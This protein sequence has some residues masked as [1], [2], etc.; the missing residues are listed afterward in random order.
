MLLFLK[1]LGCWYCWYFGCLTSITE[2]Y[3]KS[4]GDFKRFNSQ[5][6]AQDMHRLSLST[7]ADASEVD[8]ESKETED[9]SVYQ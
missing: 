2:D 1:K 8:R 7:T 9:D 3:T 4:G 6:R 5:K